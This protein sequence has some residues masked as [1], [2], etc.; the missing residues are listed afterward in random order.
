MSEDQAMKN[1]TTAQEWSRIIRNSATNAE[2]RAVIEALNELTG[3]CR[4]SGASVM[5][6]CAQILGQ[7]ISDSG[8]EISV[9]MRAG[10]LSL[11]DGFAMQTATLES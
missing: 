2:V 10:L 6:A 9:E 11:V 8:P 1:E 5:V 7:S 4:A 3:S